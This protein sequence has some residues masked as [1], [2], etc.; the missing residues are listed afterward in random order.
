M[1][2][3]GAIDDQK[4]FIEEN[5][6]KNNKKK[7]N[8]FQKK[9]LNQTPKNYLMIKRLLFV[10]PLNLIVIIHAKTLLFKDMIY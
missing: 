5:E 3:L 1:D 7:L 6:S 2:K 10:K 9:E 4:K 8:I